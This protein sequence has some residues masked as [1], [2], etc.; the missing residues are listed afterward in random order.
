MRRPSSAGCVL[1]Q[2]VHSWACNLRQCVIVMRGRFGMQVNMAP[3]LD[4]MAKVG[5]QHER[6]ATICDC[7]ERTFCCVGIS[8]TGP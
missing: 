6:G 8:S 7:H 5:C 4:I 1:T 3:D 2:Q